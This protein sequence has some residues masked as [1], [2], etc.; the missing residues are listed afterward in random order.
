[1]TQNPLLSIVITSYTTE[2]LKD[3]FELLDSIKSQ[4]LLTQQ[5]QRTQ[6]TIEVIF[7]AERS[8]ELYEKV[9]EYG[10]R[11]LG[12]RFQVIGLNIDSEHRTWNV[13][14]GTF[15]DGEPGLSAA[16]N[17]GVMNAKGDMVGFVDDDVVLFP[18]WAEE[19]VKTYEDDSAIGVTGPAFPLWED[20]SM[21]WLPEEFYWI[22][23]CSAFTGWNGLRPVRSAWGNNMSFRKEA[24]NYCRFSQD[25]GQTMGEQE[26]WKA[27]PVDDA[28]FS[29]NLRLKTRKSILFN[30]RVRVKHK[31]Y[32]YRLS[33]KFIRGQCYWQGYSKALLRKTYPDDPDTRALVREHDLLRRILFK[34][35]PRTIKQFFTSPRV[36]W[37][38]FALTITVLFYVALGYLSAY[39]KRLKDWCEKRI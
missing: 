26:A 13:E 5:T 24:F 38:R 39:N 35:L 8:R 1:M 9:K 32:I 19:M 29:I 2:R 31:V 3:I 28:E 16:R 25:F 21:G 33:Q 27:G 17:L 23:S 36:T 34:L 30:P 11:V 37:K 15:V 7:V 18:D 6:S 10:E 14:H 20:Q 12:P 4:T 22:I